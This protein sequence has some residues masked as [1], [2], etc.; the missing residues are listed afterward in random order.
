V[1]PA[2]PAPAEAV[3]RAPAALAALGYRCRIFPGCRERLG[4]LAGTDERRCAD[5]QSAFADPGIDAV[6]CLRGGYGSGRLLDRIEWRKLLAHPKPFI[7]YSDITALHAAFSNAGRISFHGPMLASDLMSPSHPV[8]SLGLGVLREGL[9]AGTLWRP[10]LESALL[11]RPGTAAGRL[12][13]GNLS[14]LCSLLATPWAL[15]IRDGVL[16]LEEVGEA[17]YRIDRLL[18]QLRLAGALEQARGFLLGSFS[19]SED[20]SDVL[21][22]YLGSLDKPV[23]GGW[24]A[25]HLPRNTLLPLGARVLL[26]ADRG[27]LQFLETVLQ[28]GSPLGAGSG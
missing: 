27:S 19:G 7:G 12:V 4:F 22:H 16:F 26:D 25:G 28:P 5:L 21:A 2:G 23:L 9:P 18:N 8:E 3:E 15:D 10:Q 11:H 14:L 24:P 1:A 13:G 20:P 6:L 17:P